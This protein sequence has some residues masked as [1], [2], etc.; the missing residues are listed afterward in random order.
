MNSDTPIKPAT[1]RKLRSTPVNDSP[2]TKCMCST[3]PVHVGWMK[4]CRPVSSYQ[5]CLFLRHRPSHEKVDLS[6]ELANACVAVCT[7]FIP[8]IDLVIKM[9]GEII[10]T[11]DNTSKEIN[12]TRHTSKLPEKV[13]HGGGSKNEEMM[14]VKEEITEDDQGTD[15]QTEDNYESD[16]EENYPLFNSSGDKLLTSDNLD[17][18]NRESEES[19]KDYTQESEQTTEETPSDALI[20][21]VCF[22]IF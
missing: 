7:E 5:R 9:K 1:D 3:C 11:A 20:I 17:Q 21:Q 15:D 4:A 10:N 18:E 19:S 14:D 13:K 8:F 12:F 16:D 6:C 2:S 22:N